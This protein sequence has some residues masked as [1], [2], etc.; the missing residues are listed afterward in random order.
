MDGLFV[1]KNR[2]GGGKRENGGNLDFT[3]SI[4]DEKFRKNEIRKLI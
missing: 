1:K 4:A 3:G 2:S